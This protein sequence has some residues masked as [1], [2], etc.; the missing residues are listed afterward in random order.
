MLGYFYDCRAVWWH[1]VIRNVELVDVMN[2]IVLFCWT[3][4]CY[5]LLT[6]TSIDEP[7]H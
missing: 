2:H 5:R 3:L 7:A 4:A 6:S 1:F